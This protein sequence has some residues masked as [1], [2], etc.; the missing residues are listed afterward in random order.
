M[1]AVYEAKED[2]EGSTDKPSQ[3]KEVLMTG[4]IQRTL[5]AHAQSKELEKTPIESA[6]KEPMDE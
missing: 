1:M 3:V 5:K 2:T 6:P 4:V